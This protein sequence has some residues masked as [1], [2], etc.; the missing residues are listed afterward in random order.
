[1]HLKWCTESRNAKE[2]ATESEGEGEGET[3]RKRKKRN[4]QKLKLVRQRSVQ[5]KYNK[6]VNFDKFKKMNK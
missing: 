2:R 5:L 3:E 6:E 4:C 1:M